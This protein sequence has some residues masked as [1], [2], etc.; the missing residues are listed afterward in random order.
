[1]LSATAN[2]G[3][4]AL[5]T[6]PLK[7]LF[8]LEKSSNDSPGRVQVDHLA[9]RLAQESHH[10]DVSAATARALVYTGRVISSCGVI[11]AVTLGSMVVG[12]IKMLQQLGFALGLGM[13]ID[14]FLIR[15]LL[16]PA[17]L[18]LAG[19]TLRRAP[20]FLR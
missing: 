5:A 6:G 10:L 4:I 20:A 16:L 18:L 9:V 17:F 12:E 1:M 11:M 2:L 19:R 7:A 13:L 3:N 15:P 14:T 8:H